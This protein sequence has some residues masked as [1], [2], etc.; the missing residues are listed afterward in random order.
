MR[1]PTTETTSENTILPTSTETLSENT[2]LPTSRDTLSENTIL[3]T[4]TETLSENTFL[5]T[6]TETETLSENTI[7][8]TST[9]TLSEN[10]FLPTLTE[11]TLEN[12]IL[13]TSTPTSPFRSAGI[14]IFMYTLLSI[15]LILNVIF[16]GFFFYK[17]SFCPC[18][19]YHKEKPTAP[20]KKYLELVERRNRIY[21]PGKGKTP[22][23]RSNSFNNVQS[24]TIYTSIS[25]LS[26]STEDVYL[27]ES[28]G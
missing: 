19:C 23:F 4:S 22:L 17:H 2:I 6:L 5:P 14:H 18:K 10:T 1:P 13:P 24:E 27:N 20:S 11:T 15:S 7:L 21:N 28:I 8:P 16:I 25:T 9:E 3:P 12:T 26:E